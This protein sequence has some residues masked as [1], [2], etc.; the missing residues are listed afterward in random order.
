[1]ILILIDVIVTQFS[2]G[3]LSFKHFMGISGSV[4]ISVYTP[5]Y[6]ILKRRY[7]SKLRY[8]LNLHIFGNVISFMLISIHFA[9]KIK[10]PQVYYSWLWEG[11]GLYIVL[12]VL[13]FTGL[14]Q[15]FQIIP[16]KWIQRYSIHINRRFHIFFGGL[17]FVFLLIHVL[18]NLEII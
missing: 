4:F 2:I 6:I 13:I 11:L 14:V 18:I 9:V 16:K 12:I 17:F 7:N 5:I 1:M 8:F 15:R 10:E 3:A